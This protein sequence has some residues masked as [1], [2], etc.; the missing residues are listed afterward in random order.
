LDKVMPVLGCIKRRY[1]L[2]ARERGVVLPDPCIA[3]PKRYDGCYKTEVKF[4]DS[5]QK[6]AV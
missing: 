2:E 5:D 4:F 1:S 3:C 6:G